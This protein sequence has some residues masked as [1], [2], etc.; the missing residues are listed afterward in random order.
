V[1]GT[2]GGGSDAGGR[3]SQASG[4]GR[5]MAAKGRA[6][7]P[8]GAAQVSVAGGLR[9]EPKPNLFQVSSLWMAPTGRRRSRSHSPP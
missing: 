4:P 3:G 2:A 6:A 8:L 9:M 7:A 5:P 1:P